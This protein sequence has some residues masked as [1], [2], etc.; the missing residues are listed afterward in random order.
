MSWPAVGFLF[1][2]F[3]MP[4]DESK[5]LA[6]GSKVR[7]SEAMDVPEWCEWDDDKGRTSGVLKKR[8]QLMFFRG[9]KKITAEVVYV[10]KESERE[11]LRRQGR[12]K[13]RLREP[14]GAMLTITADPSKLVRVR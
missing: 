11:K 13:L 6:V 3:I 14:S 4:F 9:D 7:V 5:N 10:P 8:L 1:S 2:G 12:V